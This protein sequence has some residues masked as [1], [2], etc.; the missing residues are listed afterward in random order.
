MKCDYDNHFTMD[1]YIKS[2]HCIPNN[3]SKISVS[4]SPCYP[5]CRFS[6]Q[7]KVSHTKK[8]EMKTALQRYKAV[9]GTRHENHDTDVDIARQGI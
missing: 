8:Q 4:L 1:I 2:S 7:L 9:T 3:F 5:Y 6:F